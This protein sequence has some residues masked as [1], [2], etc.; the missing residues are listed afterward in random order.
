MYFFINDK[1]VVKLIKIIEGIL[2]CHIA[3]LSRIFIN[4]AFID[5]ILSK[6]T[7]IIK[8]LRNSSSKKIR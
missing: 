1:L 6:N 7:I 5:K 3:F 2:S 8:L 4:S